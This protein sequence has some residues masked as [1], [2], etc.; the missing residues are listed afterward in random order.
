[1]RKV[2]IPFAVLALILLGAY[3]LPPKKS[4][5]D[6]TIVAFGD[7]LTYG[8]GS[9]KG[10][11]FVSILEENLGVPIINMGVPGDT[12]AKAL[13]RIDLITVQKPDIVIVLL[14]GNDLLQH[15]PASETARNIALI[16]AT[17]R[18]S[19]SKVLLLPLSILEGVWGHAELMSDNLHPNDKGYAVMAAQIEPKLRK[20]LP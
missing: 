17:L 5:S 13:A 3:F 7:S 11:G 1:M 9:E 15:V 2:L 8:T 6:L 19:G 16:D 12:T 4:V 20:L 10:G 18:N 14:G